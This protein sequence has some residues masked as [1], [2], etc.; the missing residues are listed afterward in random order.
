MSPSSRGR[1]PKPLGLPGG[2]SGAGAGTQAQQRRVGG[3]PYF[4]VLE[5]QAEQHHL[6]LQQQRLQDRRQRIK[7]IQ[8]ERKSTVIVYYSQDL[9]QPKHSELLYEMLQILGPQKRLDLFLL[10]PGGYPDAAFKMAS[11]CRDFAEENFG[12]LIPHYAKS[13]ATLL[14]LGADEL[15]MGEPSELGP[16]DPRIQV[17]DNYGR[18]VQVSATVVKDAL[19][20]IESLVG[21]FADK[22][23]KYMPLIERINLEVLGEYKRALESSKQ[24]AEEL[25]KTGK[26]LKDKRKA[27]KLAVSLAEGYYSHGYPIGARRAADELGLNVSYCR[28]DGALAPLWSAMWQLHTLCNDALTAN[29]TLTMFESD[30]AL[31]LP[32][33]NV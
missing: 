28:D 26:L 9:L 12:V 14:S 33:R 5:Q 17:P 22:A 3:I 31:L 25:L 4:A 1:P 15:V 30:M 18:N 29:N 20:L 23:L 24:Y 16:I 8:D 2:G 21:D 11:F 27:K 7:T 19:E 10:S 32:D 6:A 13:A